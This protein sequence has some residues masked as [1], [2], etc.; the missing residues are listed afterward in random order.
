MYLFLQ[1]KPFFTT[2][3]SIINVV[4]KKNL[5][6]KCPKVRKSIAATSEIQ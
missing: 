4:K 2:H 6:E 1:L 5:L 3:L